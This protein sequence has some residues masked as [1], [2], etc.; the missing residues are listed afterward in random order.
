MLRPEN[1]PAYW[2]MR[3]QGQ[4]SFCLFHRK[5]SRGVRQVLVGGGKDTVPQHSASESLFPRMTQTSLGVTPTPTKQP[6]PHT[7]DLHT[8]APKQ[9]PTTNQQPL[10]RKSI[11]YSGHSLPCSSGTHGVSS[12]S[13]SASLN[14]AAS[15]SGCIS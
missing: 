7:N 1:E 3:D 2:V 4:E 10:S 15:G 5:Q 13:K 14:G 6:P 8:H 11:R 9:H 12:A